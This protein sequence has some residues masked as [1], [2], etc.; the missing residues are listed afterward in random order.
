M[1]EYVEKL[2]EILGSSVSI[3]VSGDN[4]VINISPTQVELPRRRTKLIGIR[5]QDNS[6]IISFPTNAIGLCGVVL[7][8][9]LLGTRF[10]ESGSYVLLKI[11]RFIGATEIAPYIKKWI[12]A[13]IKSMGANAG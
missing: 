4:W 6:L 10:V 3:E 7:G 12:D 13:Y 5:P 8:G 9:E 11:N 1:E 2:R